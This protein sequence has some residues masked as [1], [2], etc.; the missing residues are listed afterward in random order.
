LKLTVAYFDFG[1]SQNRDSGKV[2]FASLGF[3]MRVVLAAAVCLAILYAI[4]GMYFDGQH[5]ATAGAMLRNIFR[6]L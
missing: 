4:D 1:A 6:T 3:S 2:R 5:F